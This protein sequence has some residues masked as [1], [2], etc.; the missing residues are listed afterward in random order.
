M[1][2]ILSK[3][4][5]D[6]YAKNLEKF[7]HRTRNEIPIAKDQGSWKFRSKGQASVYKK[8]QKIG[9]A[10]KVLFAPNYT[11]QSMASSKMKVVHKIGA[12]LQEKV[13][14]V[15]KL[16]VPDGLAGRLVLTD[17]SKKGMSEFTNILAEAIKRNKLKII[18]IRNYQ[19]EDGAAYLSDEMI[20]TLVKATKERGKGF[21]R[22]IKIFDR[23][24]SIQ[25][26]GYTSLHINV[27]MEG[28]GLTELQV[29]GSLI[30]KLAETL[31][32]FYDTRSG[33]ELFY[34]Y[35]SNPDIVKIS[36]QIKAMTE[37]ETESYLAYAKSY[38]S[39]VRRVEAGESLSAPQL[40]DNI[41]Q[42]SEL[43]IGNIWDLIKEYHPGGVDIPNEVFSF[44]DFID[45][46]LRGIL[47]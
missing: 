43:E 36:N 19:H 41:S 45:D 33:K 6:L 14:G 15:S 27:W 1:F 37:E 5:A 38:Y 4:L 46:L 3:D 11:A 44:K 23:E 22:P 16:V 21:N 9:V 7:S 31:H 30:D 13:T 42:Y 25:P 20:D 26:M 17:T 28:V 39:Y 18:S 12:A 8:L 2:T 35:Q 24:S 29:R 34:K 47:V 10:K 40:P 32:I